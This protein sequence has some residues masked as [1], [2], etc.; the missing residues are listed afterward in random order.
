MRVRT[1]M[2]RDNPASL[3]IPAEG[4]P[5]LWSPKLREG[6]SS[7]PPQKRPNPHEIKVPTYSRGRGVTRIRER[8][9]KRKD[10][11]AII[12]PPP[13]KR[14]GHPDFEPSEAQREMVKT[15][16]TNGI[17]HKD[18]R[19]LILN[20]E[21]KR[22]ID[23]VTFRKAFQ[24]E[25]RNGYQSQK[26]ATS[27]TAFKM[28]TG[29]D[30][31]YDEDTGDLIRPRV[32]PNISA[33]KWYEMTRFGYKEGSQVVLTGPDGKPLSP[34]DAAQINIGQVIFMMPK[35]GF[36]TRDPKDVTPQP[37]QI[38]GDVEEVVEDADTDA[39]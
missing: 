8:V 33:L 32:E 16:I 24:W 35:N 27:L 21:T 29:S 28:A 14:R 25:I 1:R 19:K 5:S 37:L 2:Q 20:P 15:G 13:P 36:E 11:V 4:E 26:L 12:P 38:E 22:P 31:V 23:K 9:R 10:V 17:T 39:A 34:G 3:P 7:A 6:P 30:A 18:L